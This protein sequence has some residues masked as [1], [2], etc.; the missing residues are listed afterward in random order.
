M[1]NRFYIGVDVHRKSWTV[2]IVHQG[3]CLSTHRQPPSVFTLIEAIRKKG[4]TPRT[5][6]FVYEIGP[7]GFDLYAELSELGYQVIVV[8]P[9]HVPR[10]PGNRVKTDRR[11]SQNLA[12][13]HAAGLFHGIHVPSAEE[14]AVRDLV[15][16]RRQLIGCRTGMI[17]RV[18]AK[19][20]F[21][22]VP[23]PDERRGR[24]FRA[25]ILSLELPEENGWA[26][27][28]V[29]AVIDALTEQV[30]KCDLELRKVFD[31]P[32]LLAPL[33]LLQS[34]PGIGARTARAILA[35][36]GGVDRFPTAQNFA[37]WLG[38]TPAEHSSGESVHRGRITRQGNAHIRS[39]LTE[40]AWTA[41]RRDPRLRRRYAVL[42]RR[43]GPEKAAIAAARSTGV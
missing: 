17:R 21:Q 31:R 12:V 10:E 8:S 39:L 24:T 41:N 6:R 11:D 5:A 18:K 1:D 42:A 35:E 28:H 9:T 25:F 14:R 37:S 2:S 43:I 7:T 33:T 38:L 30:Q 20:L 22:N 19:L 27:G 34:I 15:R 13:K 32:A 40:A 16:T 3:E 36:R 29:V 23:Y 4:A 26:I